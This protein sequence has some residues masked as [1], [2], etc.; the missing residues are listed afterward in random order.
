MNASRGVQSYRAGQDK[1]RKYQ[2]DNKSE[3]NSYRESPR[4]EEI[5]WACDDNVEGMVMQME[6]RV[7]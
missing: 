3:R 6:R 2:K 1:K 7:I 5:P 4:K